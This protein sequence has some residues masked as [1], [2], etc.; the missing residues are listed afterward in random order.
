MGA[1]AFIM[2]EIVGIPYANIMKAGLIPALLFFGSL[3]FVVHMQAV[4][5]DIK[6][7]ARP[8]GDDDEPLWLILLK[9]GQ[10]I[11]PF[12]T[13]VGMM[14]NGYSPFKASYISILLL[15]AS[16]IIWQRKIDLNLFAR[17]ARAITNG[18]K[19]VI[20]IAAACAAAGIIAG[21]LGFTGLGSK[22]SGLIITA[23]GGIIFF[24]L[25]LTMVTAIILGMG[26]PTTAA[27]LVLATVVA[28]ALAELGVPMLTAHM[29][30]FFYGCVSTITP[31]V[32][33]ASYVA[34][35][36]ANADIN[37]VGW[38]AFFYGIASY[39]L[40]FMFLYGPGLLMQGGWGE[41]A[42][43]VISGFIGV[44][45]IATF[46]VGYMKHALPLWQRGVMAIAGI[47]LLYQDLL[48]DIIGL[49]LVI[50][51]VVIG[52]MKNQKHQS[53]AA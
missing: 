22:I 1:A 3:F 52:K 47:A 20:P 43:A 35:G 6:P 15:L 7:A 27:Y 30:V 32:A 46:V 44:Y 25:L 23:S 41:I 45:C 24:A 5:N 48:T 26:L 36:I 33:L 39:I 42:L 13:L 17:S 2:A 14:V 8:A 29:F 53:R 19:S 38:T 12:V 28:P 16:N 18:A 37:K 50:G 31:P 9:G 40:P 4:K 34:A 51:I 11:I 21:T 49:T 10:Y